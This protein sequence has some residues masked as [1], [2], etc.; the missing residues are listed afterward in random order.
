M[1]TAAVQQTVVAENCVFAGNEADIGGAVYSNG[2]YGEIRFL[3]C[4]ITGNASPTSAGGVY[5]TNHGDTGIFNCILWGNT[6]PQICQDGL[7]LEVAYSDVQGGWEGLGNIDA[8]PLFAE[9]E[10]ADYR[11][12][13][14]S[15]CIDAADNTAVPP[16]VLDLDGDGDTGEPIPFDLDGNPRFVDDP[17]TEDT[18]HGEPPI[19][20]MGA[21]EYQPDTCPADFDDDGDVDAADLLYLLGAWGTPHG[22]VD[23][24]GDTDTA[25]LLALLGAWGPC[26]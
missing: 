16:D 12:S 26:P 23:G 25:D 1:Y 15:P 3:N 19:V 8:D 22:D 11:L 4:T 10:N 18:G 21:Y 13:S 17:D 6:T 24:D 14:T 2:I 7:A 20:D 9:P 5:N